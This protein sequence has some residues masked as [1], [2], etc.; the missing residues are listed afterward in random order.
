MILATFGL[1][2][3][4][5]SKVDGAGQATDKPYPRPAGGAVLANYADH[6]HTGQITA[7]VQHSAA[8]WRSKR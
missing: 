8:K 7:A 3:R 2:G 5:E 1:C 6:V 4:A